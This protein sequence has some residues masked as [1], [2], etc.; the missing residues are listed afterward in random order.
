MKLPN[1]IIKYEDSILIKLPIVLNVLQNGNKTI[2]E[3]YKEVKNQVN[4]IAEFTEILCC[5][6]ALNKIELDNETG[7]LHYAEGNME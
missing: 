2:L 6:Y 4:N 5:L 3:T 7:G 1:K